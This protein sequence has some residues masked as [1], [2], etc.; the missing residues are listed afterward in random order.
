MHNSSLYS[1]VWRMIAL[2]LRTGKAPTSMQKKTTRW[3]C[4]HT[5][6]CYLNH[7][8]QKC[9]VIILCQVLIARHI[10]NV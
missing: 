6:V 7:P 1:C 9:L 4:S 2:P 8:G 3:R 5:V 10:P